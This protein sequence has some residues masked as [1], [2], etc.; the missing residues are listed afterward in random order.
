M[1]PQLAQGAL[2]LPGGIVLIDRRIIENAQ[3]PAVPA[4][5]I[6]AAA[7]GSFRAFDPLAAV[8]KCR[9]ALGK[10]VGL[11]TTGDLPPESLVDYA[12]EITES[13]PHFPKR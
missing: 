8:L 3:D 10:T 1:L 4:G 7:A 5:Y 12:R 9:R 2:A 11:L 13:E 6:V